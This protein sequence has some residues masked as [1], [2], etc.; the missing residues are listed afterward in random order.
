MRAKHQ[1]KP[2]RAGQTLYNDDGVP[3]E[4]MSVIGK[5]GFGQAYSAFRMSD[6]GKR[7]VAQVCVKVCQSADDWHGEAFFGKIVRG[8][9]R[10]VQMLDSF[11]ASTGSGRDQVR[12]HVLVFEY[13]SEGTVDD[14]VRGSGGVPW[15]ETRVRKEIGGVLQ[16]LAQMHN[17]GV[18]HRDLTP[19]NVFLRD[20]HLV[21]GDFGI[22]RM[23]LDPKRAEVTAFTPAYTPR[24]VW[25]RG[26]WGPAEDVFQLGLL[27]CTLLTGEVWTAE[28]VNTLRQ[29]D[30]ADDLK[31]W[32]WHATAASA[33]K[34]LDAADA[35][36]ALSS[37]K[38]V[39]VLPGR[40]P[41]SMFG[42][43]VVFTGKLDHL[44]REQ[45]TRLV[46]QAGAQVQSSVGDTTTLLVRGPVRNALSEF[47]GR[48]L[49]AV[50]E[51]RRLGQP[52]RIITGRQLERL[53][54]K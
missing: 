29:L 28:R 34:Y 17:V 8:N 18:T 5:G 51:R 13:M 22:T 52:I 33:K 32:I 38:S 4:I 39:T 47:E 3:Y 20:G 44:T 50:R 49:F 54:A 24:V 53:V 43:K 45:A 2:L 16:L 7:P 36:E 40:A 23:T 37:L 30:V 46:T 19:A 1:V 27:T 11:V 21:L 35:S 42:Q 31:C 41:T 9:D 26:R 25:S 15:R 48:K 14:A 10:A 6:D 12:R